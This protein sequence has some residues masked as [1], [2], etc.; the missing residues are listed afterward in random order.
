MLEMRWCSTTASAPAQKPPPA[1]SAPRERA[2]DHVDR[3]RVGV[4][5]LGGAAA[6]RAE[7][8]VGPGFVEDDAEFVAGFEMDLDGC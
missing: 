6:R 2:D 5:G 7:D 1:Q 3:R 8:A 4:R